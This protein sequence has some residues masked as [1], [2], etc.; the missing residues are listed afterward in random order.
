MKVRS[1]K[2]DLQAICSVSIRSTGFIPQEGRTDK[3]RIIK[4]F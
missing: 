4:N 1:G 3:S 2:C